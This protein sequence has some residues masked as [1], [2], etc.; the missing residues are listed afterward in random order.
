MRPTALSNEPTFV[1]KPVQAP[2]I[3]DNEA[4]RLEVLRKLCVLD[5]AEEERF[6]VLTRIAQKHFDVNICL[7]SLIDKERQW[8]KSRQGLDAMETPR[9]ISF[10]G[11]AIL[12][13]EIF[14]IPDALKDS[15][16][17]DNPLVTG[18]PHVIFYAGAP[19]HAPGGFRIGTLCII[20]DTPREFSTAELKVLRYLANAVE[21]ELGYQELN[22]MKDRLQNDTKLLQDKTQRLELATN[23]GNIGIWSYDISDAALNWDDK[24]YS[25]FG[26]SNRSKLDVYQLWTDAL[27]IDDKDATLKD[28]ADAIKGE[29]DFHSQY[30]ILLP[31][32]EV[33]NM[34]ANAHTIYNKDGQASQIVG[35]NQDI[36]AKI[37]AEKALIKH[38]RYDY[39]TDLPNRYLFDD[40]LEQTMNFARRHDQTFALLTLDLDGFKLI[41][42][43]KGHDCG[44][45]ILKEVSRRLKQCLRS[46]DFCARIG[47]DEFCVIL[48]DV[49]QKMDVAFI[50]KKIINDINR[51]F[52]YKD[53]QLSIGVSIGVA[54]YPNDGDEKQ[55][56]IK[57]SD[58]ALY[59]SKSLGRN[60]LQS[61][62]DI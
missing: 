16:F 25:L 51:S 19:L 10:C 26:L 62:G 49:S 44:D 9:D 29:K 31:S 11:H 58:V 14:Y 54:F 8:F 52:Q 38:A 47:G 27:H 61:F 53:N 12:S 39:L 57:A 30:R 15:R 48:R 3:P 20:D 2:N 59:Q 35:V 5:T 33:R 28:F 18:P 1:G 45:Y 7:V 56:L 37:L 60:Q 17:A 41:N 42:D 21:V 22:E 13:D 43:S 23:A 46:Y 6:D 36:T 40:T 24:M 4:D 32:G 55:S 50:A 34:K